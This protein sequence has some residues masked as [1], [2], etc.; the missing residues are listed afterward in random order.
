MLVV[1]VKDVRR[2]QKKPEV[3]VHRI[4]AAAFADKGSK[5]VPVG[6]ALSDLLGRVPVIGHPMKVSA[7]LADCG[8]E[9]DVTVIADQCERVIEVHGQGTRP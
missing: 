1:A 2:D 3:K 4:E 5:T 9:A 8:C 6:E 7:G